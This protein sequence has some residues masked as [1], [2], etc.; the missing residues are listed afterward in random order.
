MSSY[1]AGEMSAIF[2]PRPV[3]TR[4][5]RWKFSTPNLLGE[6]HD[7]V[8]LIVVLLRERGVDLDED[9]VFS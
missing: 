5:N 9:I 7:V 6:R 2:A 8:Y 1:M 4:K 3:G